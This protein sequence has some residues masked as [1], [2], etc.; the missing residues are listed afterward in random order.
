MNEIRAVTVTEIGV[1]SIGNGHSPL[2]PVRGGSFSELLTRVLD[3]KWS[4]GTASAPRSAELG[5]KATHEIPEQ[6][7]DL[8]MLQARLSSHH[9][10]IELLSKMAESVTSTLRR[11]QGQ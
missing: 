8:L 6:F 4:L 5:G 10:N 7:R 2:P 9:L 3:S 11:L 1:N